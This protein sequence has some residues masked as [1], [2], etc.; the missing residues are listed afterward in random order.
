MSDSH[1]ALASGERSEALAALR[2]VLA[3]LVLSAEPGQAA[4]LAR[5]YRATLAEQASLAPAETD[6]VSELA[7][8]RAARRAAAQAAQAAG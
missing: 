3:G 7:D 1:A 2:A 8:R 5:E 4:A 6:Q